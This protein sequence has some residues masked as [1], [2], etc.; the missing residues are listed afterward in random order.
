MI[1]DLLFTDQAPA[2]AS[3]ERLATFEAQFGFHLPKA[4][5]EFCSKWNGGLPSPENCFYYVPLKF[6]SFH[7]EY[8]A[9][10]KGITVDGLFGL[11]SQPKRWDMERRFL[12]WGEL[13]TI[14]IIPIS[15]DLLGNHVVLRTDSM[16]GSVLW[17]DHELWEAPERPH[18]IP[19]ADNLEMFYNSLTL[20][21]FTENV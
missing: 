19:I 10:G 6:S 20:N 7:Q 13:S 11:T 9:G 18:L 14:G 2:P 5:V 21:P 4:L 15:F 8:G 17:W 16:D 1:K 12:S 3:S